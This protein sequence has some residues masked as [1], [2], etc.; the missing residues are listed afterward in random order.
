LNGLNT[1]SKEKARNQSYTPKFNAM[2]ASGGLNPLGPLSMQ[3]QLNS[4]STGAHKM[5]NALLE[6]VLLAAGR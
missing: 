5:A 1:I 6:Q 3:H 2:T 4:P